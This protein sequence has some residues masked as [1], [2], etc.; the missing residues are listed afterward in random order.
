MIAAVL[1]VIHL[2]PVFCSKFLFFAHFT[3]FFIISHSKCVIIQLIFTQTCTVFLLDII[4]IL[5]FKIYFH[6]NL[7][8]N[9]WE[10]WICGTKRKRTICFQFKHFFYDLC[11]GKQPYL[12]SLDCSMYVFSN[13]TTTHAHIFSSF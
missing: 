4:P 12:I 11:V 5:M 3:R 9:E 1:I 6:L 8:Q 2:F 13:C 10:R 7:F